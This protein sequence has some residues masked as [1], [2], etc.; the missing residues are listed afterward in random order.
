MEAGRAIVI[1]RHE[2]PK[3]IEKPDPVDCWLLVAALL[4]PPLPLS[5]RVLALISLPSFFFL[6]DH[7]SWPVLSKPFWFFSSSVPI[8]RIA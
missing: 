1:F 3:K 7:R 4:Y 6:L 2:K 5:T 8:D